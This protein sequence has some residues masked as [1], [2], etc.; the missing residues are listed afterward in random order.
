VFS[1]E[2]R[3]GERMPP[4]APGHTHGSDSKSVQVE[5]EAMMCVGGGVMERNWL[6]T[7]LEPWAI[8]SLE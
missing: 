5:S 8:A 1:D 3:K 6:E 2:G 7:E 4:S